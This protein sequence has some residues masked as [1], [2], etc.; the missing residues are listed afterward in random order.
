MIFQQITIFLY[1]FFKYKKFYLES[2]LLREFYDEARISVLDNI[3]KGARVALYAFGTHGESYFVDLF[4]KYRFT[5]IFDLNYQ[6]FDSI[7]KDPYQIKST[8]FDFIIITVLNPKAVQSIKDF[9]I[10]KGIKEEQ[11]VVPT[12]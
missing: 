12:E 7:V 4:S 8:D 3:P 5:D 9:L 6:K 10:N 11:I 1:N 2:C